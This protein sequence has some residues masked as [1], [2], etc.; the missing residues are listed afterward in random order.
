MSN[1]D[2]FNTCPRCNTPNPTIAK[3]CFQCG[4]QLK[5]NDAPV[6]CPKCHTQN[7]GNSSYCRTCGNKLVGSGVTK[8]CPRCTNEVDA[9]SSICS[10]CGYSF[11][12]A[13]IATPEYHDEYAPV[14][15]RGNKAAAG[16]IQK[17]PKGK[18]NVKGRV[19]GVFMMLFSLA[20]IWV[21]V[22]PP[23]FKIDALIN[24]APFIWSG[25]TLY[26]GSTYLYLLTTHIAPGAF[27]AGYSVGDYVILAAVVVTALVLVVQFILGLV[28]V[29]TGKQPR[30]AGFFLLILAALVALCTVAIYLAQFDV[31]DFMAF[32]K[33]PLTSP[34]AAYKVGYSFIVGLPASLVI[35]WL[36]R[37]LFKMTKKEAQIMTIQR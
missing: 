3:F 34:W 33:S 2:N 25:S 35:V 6:V 11:V 17:A 1:L 9:N 32:L 24:F 16:R 18:G 10:K 30:G 22:M 15:A 8:I 5:S 4:A 21:L 29:F 31:L 37:L 13:G 23:F 36:V 12:V 19:Y 20:L 26:S 28:A 27:F 7:T 14:K